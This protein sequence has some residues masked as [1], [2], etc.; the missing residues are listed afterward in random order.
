MIKETTI[1]VEHLDSFSFKAIVLIH[2]KY[3]KPSKKNNKSLLQQ[4]PLLNDT[5]IFSDDETDHIY[6]QKLQIQIQ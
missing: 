6:I 3:K 2:R 5:Y 4:S 1:I